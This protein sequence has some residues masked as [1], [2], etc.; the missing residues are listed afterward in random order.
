MALA[1]DLGEFPL[2]DII[3]LVDLSKQTGGVHIKGQRGQQ[4]IEGWLYFRDG[5]I[6]AATLGNLA[7]LEAAYTFFTIHSG[8]FQFVERAQ[9]DTQTITQSN[10]VIIMEGIMYQEQWQELQKHVPA[11]ST[12]PRLVPNPAQS[13]SEI[14][15]EAEEWR[16]LTMV[17][18]KNT[19]NNIAQRS[20]LGEGRTAEILARLLSIG[21]IENRE[22]TLAET[23]FPEL[24]RAVMTSLGASARALLYDAY[25]RSGIR[26][27]NTAT[28]AQVST[29]IDIFE[30]LALRAFDLTPVRQ[31]VGEMREL[32]QQVLGHMQ[33]QS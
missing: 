31:L 27:Q 20:G 10:E 19:M 18:G 1:G 2:T 29:S 21:L 3:Q 13:S 25:G 7:P 17:N 22:P 24:E 28:P 30:T 33:H 12:I 4:L 6:I 16:V 5:K 11:R 14:S 23:L 32:S 26:D 9:P 15:L 8:P